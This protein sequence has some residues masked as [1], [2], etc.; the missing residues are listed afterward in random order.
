MYFSIFK[1]YSIDDFEKVKNGKV[2]EVE[3]KEEEVKEEEEEEAK[4]CII[5]W[6]ISEDI[7]SLKEIMKTKYTTLSCKC[8]GNFHTRCVNIWINKSNKCP[9]CRQKLNNMIVPT[10]NFNELNNSSYVVI[11]HIL[12]ILKYLRSMTF[13]LFIYLVGSFVY[14]V[15]S[16]GLSQPNLSD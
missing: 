10:E 1:H 14:Y 9:I 16:M 8:D 2:E 4:L 5:C 6:E 11:Y 15:I 3:V 13:F 12:I 7:V